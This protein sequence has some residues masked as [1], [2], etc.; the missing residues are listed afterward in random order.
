MSIWHNKT[1]WPI[2]P[3]N[4][5]IPSSK[6][7]KHIPLCLSFLHGFWGSNPVSCKANTLE[8]E[9]SISLPPVFFSIP[10]SPSHVLIRTCK[11]SEE[12]HKQM[13]WSSHHL[14]RITLPS[15]SQ[16][17]HPTPSALKIPGCPKS[18]INLDIRLYVYIY[19]NIIF[20]SA[21]TIILPLQQMKAKTPKVQA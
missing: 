7:F 15:P 5:S 8:T 10:S 9:I 1:C 16:S 13:Y 3:R 17:I 18:A 2:S 20:H 12:I 19:W 11:S 4:L 6:D 14:V 21:H